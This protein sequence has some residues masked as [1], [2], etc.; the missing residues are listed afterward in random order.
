MDLSDTGAIVGL[1]EQGT[2]ANFHTTGF[3]FSGG[4]FTHFR[5]PG[6]TD[7]SPVDINKSGEIV[8]TFSRADETGGIYGE[9]RRF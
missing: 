6:S 2:G 9:I 1:L 8:G 5:F 3:L 4:T 7:T